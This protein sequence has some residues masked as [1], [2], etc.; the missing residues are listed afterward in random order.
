MTPLHTPDEDARDY[1]TIQDEDAS[2]TPVR[3][4]SEKP[5]R[6]GGTWSGPLFSDDSSESCDGDKKPAAKEASKSPSD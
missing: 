4:Y 2:D 5:G 6:R 1:L 3:S